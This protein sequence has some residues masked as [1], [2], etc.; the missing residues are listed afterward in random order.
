MSQAVGV[1]SAVV[2]CFHPE[3]ENLRRLIVALLPDVH[4]V[5]LVNNGANNA[6][7][8]DL[9]PKVNRMD[10]G[11]NMGVAAALNIGFDSAYAGGADAVIGF[12]QDSAPPQGLVAQLR[13][14][15]NLEAQRQP[16]VRLGAIGPATCDR[17]GAHL[18]TTFAPYNWFRQRL[19]PLPGKRW[20]V[21]HLITS[22]CLIP[23]DVWTSTGPM[24]AGLFIDWV[25]VEWCGRARLAGFTLLMDGDAVLSH[26]IGNKSQAF[27][28]RHFH[29]HAAFRHYFVLRNALIIWRDQR[30]PL[31]WRTHHVL[32][33]LR[34]ILAN[35]LFAPQRLERLRCVIRG[36]QDGWAKRTGHQ[37]QLPS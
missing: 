8:S 28:G 14:D 32:Y 15:W 26:R 17:D 2:V 6:L 25:D 30:F 20:R 33:A 12:D 23:R 21:D 13:A 27:L 1:V 24:N 31:G 4:Q 5:W 10:L 3:P 36:W 37:G 19:R 16:G 7:P 22:G 9:G 29:V 34:V 35:L 18:L 11:D